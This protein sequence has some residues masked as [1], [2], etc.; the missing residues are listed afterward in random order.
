MTTSMAG[1]MRG[2]STT[3]GFM[4]SVPG[5]SGDKRDDLSAYAL[6]IGERPVYAPASVPSGLGWPRVGVRW[7]GV[8]KLSKLLNQE[9]AL[10]APCLRDDFCSPQARP[11]GAQECCGQA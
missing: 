7:R 3:C 4:R 5:Q 2:I 8:S 11:R 1:L 10:S 6:R 9:G